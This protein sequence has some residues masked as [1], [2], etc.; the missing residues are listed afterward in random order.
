[1]F[2]AQGGGRRPGRRLTGADRTRVYSPAVS[3]VRVATPAAQPL[4]QR[5]GA[6]KRCTGNSCKCEKWVQGVSPGGVRGAEPR[7]AIFSAIFI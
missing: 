5:G 2:W 4:M 1:M 6:P 7:E 3:R